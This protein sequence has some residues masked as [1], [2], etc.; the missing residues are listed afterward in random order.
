MAT[1]MHRYEAGWIL[2]SK[3]NK[4]HVLTGLRFSVSRHDSTRLLPHSVLWNPPGHLVLRHDWLLMFPPHL[5]FHLLW[6]Q[7]PVSLDDQVRL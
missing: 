7:D 1:H 4:P 6:Q 3:L 5:F 2:E